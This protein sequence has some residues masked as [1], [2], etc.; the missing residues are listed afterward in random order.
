M[1][2]NNWTG[3]KPRVENWDASYNSVKES[4]GPYAGQLW[5]N[6]G[7]SAHTTFMVVDRKEFEKEY[8]DKTFRLEWQFKA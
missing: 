8:P 5:K 2:P 7:W 6:Q 3:Q 1:T 4:L